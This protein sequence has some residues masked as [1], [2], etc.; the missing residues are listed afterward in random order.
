M[1]PWTTCVSASF[2]SFSHTDYPPTTE[3]NLQLHLCTYSITYPH[4]IK[5]PDSDFIHADFRA[6][7]IKFRDYA[8]PAPTI[9][10]TNSYSKAEPP[11]IR[12]PAFIRES[13]S[14]TSMKASPSS[15]TVETASTTLH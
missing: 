3:I 2:S 5:D 8:Y 13:R 10:P 12:T 1:C 6:L 14:S 15:R 9:S 11:E 7:N 4:Q